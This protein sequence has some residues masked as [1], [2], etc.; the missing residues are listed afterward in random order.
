MIDRVF[1]EIDLP[2]SGADWK[3]AM[4]QRSISARAALSRHRW[5]IGLMESR[6]NPGPANLRHHDAMLGCLRAAG[7]SIAMA[8]H[9][10]SLLDSYLYG[11]AMQEQSLPFDTSDEV[12]DVAKG[13]LEPFEVDEYPNLVAMIEHALEP[14]YGYGDEFEFGLD[15][16]L[17][18]LA[19][20]LEAAR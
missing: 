4:R 20:A 6:R 15:L 2:P 13:M 12:A 3:A 11:F 1:S 8:G 14:G 7:F 19:S 10:Y 9:A 17:D 16:I 5:A 18:G